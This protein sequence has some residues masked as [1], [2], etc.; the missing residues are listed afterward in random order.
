MKETH[1]DGTAEMLAKIYEE[2]NDPVNDPYLFGYVSEY[3]ALSQRTPQI[4]LIQAKH[5]LTD[6]DIMLLRGYLAAIYGWLCR[7]PFDENAR[8]FLYE[9]TEIMNY[10]QDNS[11]KKQIEEILEA[12]TSSL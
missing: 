7:G 8:D 2:G 10:T 4:I 6:G 1:W 12:T 5:Y 11:I 3:F 9:L